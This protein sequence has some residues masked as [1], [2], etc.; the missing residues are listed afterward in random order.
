M[1]SSV[2]YWSNNSS[3]FLK[4]IRRLL[5]LPSNGKVYIKFLRILVA[6]TYLF[7]FFSSFAV[8]LIMSAAALSS[9]ALCIIFTA[10]KTAN[11]SSVCFISLSSNSILT[12]SSFSFSI[13]LNS[14]SFSLSSTLILSNRSN[15]IVFNFS[16]RSNSLFLVS[17]SCCLSSNLILSNRSASIFLILSASILSSLICCNNNVIIL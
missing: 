7:S 15:S 4:Y 17:L 8:P 16:N 9:M 10:S 5:L 14:V 3:M 2:V 11:L 12:F 13:V 6:F 1:S